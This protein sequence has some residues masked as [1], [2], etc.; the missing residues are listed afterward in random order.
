M[1]TI[2]DDI[3]TEKEVEDEE[4]EDEDEDEEDEE[5]DDEEFVVP[6]FLGLGCDI[7]NRRMRQLGAKAVEDRRFKEFFG[8][9]IIVV[10]ILWEMLYENGLLPDNGQPKHL[11]WMCYFLKCYTKQALGCSVFGG[12]SGAVD[13]KTMQKWVWEFIDSVGELVDEVVST[14]PSTLC[15]LLLYCYHYYLIHCMS[16]KD[17]LRE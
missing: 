15:A 7:Q 4:D 17:K 10:E 6:D 14:S 11:L 12:T 3:S 8:T 1:A 16:T 2:L 13:P 9:S 5:E